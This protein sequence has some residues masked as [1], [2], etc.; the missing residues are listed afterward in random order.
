MYILK[1]SSDTVS[2]CTSQT[3]NLFCSFGRTAGLWSGTV[4]FP[5]PTHSRMSLWCGYLF[6]FIVLS[7][8][9]FLSFFHSVVLEAVR[10]QCHLSRQMSSAGTQSAVFRTRAGTT[11]QKGFLLKAA[12]STPRVVWRKQMVHILPHAGAAYPKS[13]KRGYTSVLTCSDWKAM[14]KNEL[15]FVVV[16]KVKTLHFKNHYKKIH[17][18]W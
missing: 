3:T 14:S 16:L 1:E 13:K 18:M 2:Q 6:T 5:F 7:S 4:L 11:E 15:S 10:A 17:K 9:F 8:H 12:A